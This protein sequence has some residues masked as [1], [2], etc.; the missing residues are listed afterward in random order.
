MENPLDVQSRTFVLAKLLEAC[1]DLYLQTSC[2]QG[3]VCFC[4]LVSVIL[5][6]KYIYMVY[7]L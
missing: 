1:I 6:C 7:N 4:K 5:M 3:I 2:L